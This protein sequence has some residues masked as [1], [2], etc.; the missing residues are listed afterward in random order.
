MFYKVQY[1]NVSTVC[2]NLIFLSFCNYRFVPGLSGSLYIY[3]VLY[4]YKKVVNRWLGLIEDE[5]NSRAS[6]LSLL[7]TFLIHLCVLFKKFRLLPLFLLVY[8][9]GY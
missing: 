7:C 4:L 3:F 1:I 2:M 5:K 6:L 9:H 8:E